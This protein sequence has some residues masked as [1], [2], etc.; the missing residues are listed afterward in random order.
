MAIVTPQ[1]PR[2]LNLKKETPRNLQDVPLFLKELVQALNRQQELI[3][4]AI[5]GLTGAD[6]LANRPAVAVKGRLYY[7]TDAPKHLYVDDGTAWQ[8][9]V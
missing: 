5:Q 9:L 8:L 7:N 2:R 6:V 3:S 1:V 4:V